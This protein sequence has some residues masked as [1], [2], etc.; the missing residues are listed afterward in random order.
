MLRSFHTFGLRAAGAALAVIFSCG[1]PGLAVSLNLTSPSENATVRGTVRL[2]AEARG[3]EGL[4]RVEFRVN[5]RPLAAKGVSGPPFELLWNS[6]TIWNGNVELEAIARNASGELL[7]R[8]AP[9]GFQ[10]SNGPATA[11]HLEPAPSTPA[12]GRIEWSIEVRDAEPVEAVMFFVDGEEVGIVWG[13][14]RRASL[15]LDTTRFADGLHELTAAVHSLNEPRRP[16]AM[17]QVRVPFL[18]GRTLRAVLPRYREIFLA[19]GRTLALSPS[20]LYTNG[21]R[22]PAGDAAFRTE[23]PAVA[24]VDAK[25]IVRATGPG[26]TGVVVQ[27]GG[28]TARVAVIVGDPPGVPHFTRDGGITDSYVP[29]ESLF[30]RTLFHLDPADLDRTPDLWAQVQGAGIN[31]LTSSFWA[32]GHDIGNPTNFEQWRVRWDEFWRPIEAAARRH[33]LSLLLI[34]DNV[35][36][37]P[38]QLG[39]VLNEPWGLPG[40]RYAFGRLRDSGLVV[41]VEMVDEVSGLWG[42]TPTPEDGRWLD[43]TPP[44]PDDAFTQLIDA[45]RSVPG[46]SPITWPVLWLSPPEAVKNW[47]G[48]SIFSDYAS[49]Y[50]DKL[51]WRTAYPWGIS[52]PQLREALEHVT[53]KRRGLIQRDRP[54]L[55]QMSAVGPFYTKLGPGTEYVPGQD[56]LQEPGHTPVSIGAQALYAMAVG[57]AGVR[58]YSYDSNGWKQ[59]RALPRTGIRDLQTGLDPFS[60]GTDRWD[61]MAAAFQLIDRVE[62]YLFQPRLPS[63]ELGPEFVT[64]ARRGQRN[65]LL[66]AVNLTEASAE[67]RPDLTP[68]QVPGATRMIR[69]RLHGARLTTDVLPLAAGDELTLQ[70]GEGVVWLWVSPRRAPSGRRTGKD[71]PRTGGASGRSADRSA[72]PQGRRQ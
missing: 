66:I 61:A 43:R 24:A 57:A 71:A 58:V 56:W 70:P 7:A 50:W 41:G 18:N 63:P 64:G 55:L 35:A 17:T 12:V 2:A 46:H 53:V 45:I 31:T 62:P 29:G 52:L 13:D 33:G 10:I 22:S 8:S 54:L 26:V 59:N 72:R 36:R 69:Y 23:D 51:A 27:A 1:G 39:A 4:A 65:A 42:I 14:S 44:I 5:G 60:V 6:A 20:L 19:P 28:R 21:Q 40:I 30:V 25:G 15:S 68:Y 32:L 16:L 38:A 47:M 48:S 37:D 67:I 11:R 49:M 3:I 34:G 9:L